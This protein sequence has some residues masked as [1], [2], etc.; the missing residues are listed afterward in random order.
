MTDYRTIELNSIKAYDLVDRLLG[1]GWIIHRNGLFF[2]TLKK[3]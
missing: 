3:R 2:I 1:Q